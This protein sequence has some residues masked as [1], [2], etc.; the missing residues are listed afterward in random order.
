MQIFSHV[1][2]IFVYSLC[3]Q[4]QRIIEMQE[5]INGYITWII[6]DDGRVVDKVHVVDKT[7]KK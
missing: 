3:H 1:Y 4:T 7:I 6:E 2:K 5:D